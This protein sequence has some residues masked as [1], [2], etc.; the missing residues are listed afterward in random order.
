[1]Y[2]DILRLHRS[3]DKCRASNFTLKIVCLPAKCAGFAAGLRTTKFK[4]APLW[5]VSPNATDSKLIN[6]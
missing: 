6:E 2:S 1:M 3:W 5:H 4:V